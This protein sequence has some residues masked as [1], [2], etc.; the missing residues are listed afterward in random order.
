[1][2]LS[3]AE[4]SKIV[5]EFAHHDQDTG[6]VEVQVALLTHDIAKINEHIKKHRKDVHCRRGLVGK[7]RQRESL[8]DYLYRID[9][10]RYLKTVQTLMIRDKRN[11]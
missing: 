2:A 3:V 10:V 11:K 6:S 1:V 7:V 8:L 4:K 5:G 9:S